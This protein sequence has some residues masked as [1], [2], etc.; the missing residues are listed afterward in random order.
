LAERGHEW[1]P[2]K[3]TPGPNTHPDVTTGDGFPLIVLTWTSE[4]LPQ[5][6]SAVLVKR[7]RHGLSIMKKSSHLSFAVFNA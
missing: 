5:A 6:P 2:S 4:S 7:S 3:S 1:S